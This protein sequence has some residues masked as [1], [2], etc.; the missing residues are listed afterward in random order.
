MGFLMKKNRTWIIIAFVALFLLLGAVTLF[1]LGQKNTPAGNFLG[2]FFPSSGESK[3]PQ[4]NISSSFGNQ[5]NFDETGQGVN[6][7]SLR[8]ITANPVA[9]DIAIDDGN[10]IIVRYVEKETGNV[11]DAPSSSLE[12]TRVTNTTIPRI[13]NAVFMPDGESVLLRLLGEDR[14]TEET[15][16]AKIEGGEGAEGSV[17]AL[18]GVFLPPNITS[19]SVSPSGSSIFY[20]LPQKSGSEGIETTN[21]GNRT[22]KIFSHPLKEWGVSYVSNKALALTTKP[23]FA[24]FGFLYLINTNSGDFIQTL[25]GIRGLSTLVQPKS[26][27]ILYSESVVNDILLNVIDIETG[28]KL[29][30][31]LSTLAEKCIWSKQREDIAYCAVPKN[32]PRGNYPDDWYQGKVSFSDAL[33]EINTDTEETTLLVDPENVARESID[34]VKLSLSPDETLLTFI[35]KKDSSLWSFALQ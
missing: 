25:G 23:S 26:S 19:F 11:F 12:I 18:T 8:K 14:E 16:L 22:S 21:G 30:L 29:T 20:I 28:K 35:N 6:T 24:V 10:E 2:N 34:M 7:Q 17:G 32:I 1:F 27:K 5:G 15:F 31:P 3:S 13:A 9:G 33:W 4:G